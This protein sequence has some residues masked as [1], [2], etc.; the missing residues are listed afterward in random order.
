MPQQI[1]TNKRLQKTMEKAIIRIPISGETADQMPAY[2]IHKGDQGAPSVASGQ[3][4][5]LWGLITL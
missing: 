5:Q 1:I 3:G 4:K 2:K